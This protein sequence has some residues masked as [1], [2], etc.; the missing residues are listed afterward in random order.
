MQHELTIGSHVYTID[1]ENLGRVKNV[2]GDAFQLDVSHHSDYWLDFASVRSANSERVTVT[3]K[4]SELGAYRLDHP[5][6]AGV[7]QE[8][9]PRSIEPETMRGRNF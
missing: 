5:H 8:K 1:E 7:Q 2:K 9:L 3:F 4:K 6:D